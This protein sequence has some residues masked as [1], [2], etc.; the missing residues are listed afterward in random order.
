MR[1]KKELEEQLLMFPIIGIRT[2]LSSNKLVIDFGGYNI[3][4]CC[5]V[6]GEKLGGLRV[7]TRV[8]VI[9]SKL[10]LLI[11]DIPQNEKAWDDECGVRHLITDFRRTHSVE[12]KCVCL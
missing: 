10:D 3:R 8:D 4:F 5:Q 1:A 7:T 11:R 2:M 12:E 9:G 6:D